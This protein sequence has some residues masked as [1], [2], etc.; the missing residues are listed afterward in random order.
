MAKPRALARTDEAWAWLD[1]SLSVAR[2]K[3]LLPETAPLVVDRFAFP[4][5]RS[6]NFVI[7]GLLEEGVAG[8]VP[9]GN[10]Q[11]K[12]LG[13]WARSRLSM[14]QRR[15][16]RGPRRDRDRERSKGSGATSVPRW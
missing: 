5:L 4:A 6:L 14:L 10:A 12:S 1:D 2:L 9:P 3:E 8:L 13:E 11:A 7:H 16:S 15:C